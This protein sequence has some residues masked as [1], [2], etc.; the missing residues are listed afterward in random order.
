MRRLCLWAQC[1]A[2]Q[3]IRGLRQYLAFERILHNFYVAVDSNPEVF[4]LFILMQNG[5]E[6]S[7]DASVSVLVAP[8]NLEIFS[9]V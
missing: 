7:V 6:C 5:E 2:R 4:G 9:R 1:L 8:R 3:W